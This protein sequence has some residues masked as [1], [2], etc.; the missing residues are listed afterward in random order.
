MEWFEKAAAVN[1]VEAAVNVGNMYR[2]GVGVEK[3]LRKALSF[4]KSFAS[5]NELCHSLADEVEKE[6]QS[7][8]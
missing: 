8:S 5:R 4:F 1:V 3:D 7:P 2:L 6:L